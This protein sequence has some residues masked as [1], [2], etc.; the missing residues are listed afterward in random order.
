MSA[1]ALGSHT[2]S[3][4]NAVQPP[5][6]RMLAA[7]LLRKPLPENKCE[8]RF[9]CAGAT[10]AIVLWPMRLEVHGKQQHKSAGRRQAPKQAH[11]RP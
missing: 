4:P 2:S 7:A 11:V 1:Y 6:L 9:L 8:M 3:S 10:G 5:F